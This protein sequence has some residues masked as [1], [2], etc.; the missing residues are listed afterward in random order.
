MTKRTTW[1]MRIDAGTRKVGT[2][3]VRG[4]SRPK[5]TAAQSAVFDVTGN[6]PQV[7]A[8]FD[9]ISDGIGASPA[10]TPTYRQPDAKARMQALGRLKAGEMNK[11]EQRY[12]DHL[13]ARKRQGEVVWYRFEGI[14]FR[15]ADNTFYTPDFAVMLANGQLEAHEVKGHW[16]DDARVK[17][18]VAA[19]QYP[20]R[21]IAVT[22]GPAKSG[23]WQTEEF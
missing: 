5:M 8:G 7:D 17:V 19:D 23:G 1:P 13:E 9:D 4:D 11:T 3:H 6:R 2:A 12:A 15:L 21:F 20:V 18:K 16:Q 22:A 14:K 10:L